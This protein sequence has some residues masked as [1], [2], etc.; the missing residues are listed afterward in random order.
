MGDTEFDKGLRDKAKEF[1]ALLDGRMTTFDKLIHQ[2]PNA[3]AFNLAA[4]VERIVD[5][6]RNAIV[7]H[8]AHLKTT[9]GEMS[10]VLYKIAENFEQV[11]DKNAKDVKKMFDDQKEDSE[12]K[13]KDWNTD[14]EKAEGNHEGGVRNAGDG[15]AQSVNN[16][17]DPSG[18]DERELG[19]S[20]DGKGDDKSDGE[21][22]PTADHQDDHQGG[23]QQDG[24]Q[25]KTKEKPPPAKPAGAGTK[26]N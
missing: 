10:D 3:G 19:G 26:D 6:R 2:W 8:V 9:F 11:D 22:P 13:I 16:A 21:D 17:F 4:W 24:D 7:A 12:K 23:D 5:D 18:A 15:Y 14:R 20:G 25:G 1:D